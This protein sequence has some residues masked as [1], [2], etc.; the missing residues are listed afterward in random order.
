MSCF[1]AFTLPET[2]IAPENGWLEMVGIR[3]F[4]FGARPIFTGFG[5][6][7]QGGSP[8]NPFWFLEFRDITETTA[9]G[10]NPAPPG[11]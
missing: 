3:S 9:D 1:F 8:L 5:C 2:N 10:R 4:P 7:F 6:W 11:M